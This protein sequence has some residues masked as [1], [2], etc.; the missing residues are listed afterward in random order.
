VLIK[1]TSRTTSMMDGS[2]FDGAE[3]TFGKNS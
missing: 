1:F 2:H 3:S